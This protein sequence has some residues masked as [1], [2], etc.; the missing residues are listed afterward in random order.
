MNDGRIQMR[1]ILQ[2][3]PGLIGELRGPEAREAIV[4]AI[5]PTI[6]GE[7]LR[8]ISATVRLEDKTLV[9]AVPGIEWKREFQQ[10]AGSIVYK[11]NA[12]LKN[13]VVDRLEFVIDATRGSEVSCQISEPKSTAAKCSIERRFGCRLEDHEHG[14]EDEFSEGRSGVHGTSRCCD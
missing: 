10:H 7:Q 9:V 1:A 14:I 6:V 12:S 8:E 5:W 2:T 11:L 4:F 3:L 13:S